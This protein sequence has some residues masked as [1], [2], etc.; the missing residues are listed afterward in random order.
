MKKYTARV[1]PRAPQEESRA[2]S[3]SMTR[4]QEFVRVPNLSPIA[5]IYL[6]INDTCVPKPHM[7][8]VDVVPRCAPGCSGGGEGSSGSAVL[9]RSSRERGCKMVLNTLSNTNTR[10][11]RADR[12]GNTAAAIGAMTS[13]PGCVSQQARNHDIMTHLTGMTF[14]DSSHDSA[15]ENGH[16]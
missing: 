12:G 16:Y 3:A 7:L 2:R 6:R 1:P 14:D 8:R 11:P 15:D 9:G 10:I 5:P 4:C 13:D